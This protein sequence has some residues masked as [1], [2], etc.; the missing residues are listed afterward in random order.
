MNYRVT[1]VHWLLRLANLS[2]SGQETRTQRLVSGRVTIRVTA[3]RSGWC[4]ERSERY[5]ISYHR[6]SFEESTPVVVERGYYTWHF[7][8]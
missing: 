3:A 4:G 2:A 1:G 8:R 7:Y 6:V 5:V